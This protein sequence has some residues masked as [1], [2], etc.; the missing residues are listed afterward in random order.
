MT[1]EARHVAGLLDWGI[2]VVIEG[3]VKPVGGLGL[4]VGVR[5]SCWVDGGG[6]RGSAAS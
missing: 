4:G 1:L 6:P 5:E 3:Y 2:R